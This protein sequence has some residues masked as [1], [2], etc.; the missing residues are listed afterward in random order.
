MDGKGKVLNSSKSW[1]SIPKINT[2][3][4]IILFLFFPFMATRVAKGQIGA[5]AAAANLYHS[6][7]NTRSELHLWP[8]P[9]F[10]AMPDL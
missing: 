7:S 4:K 9:Q 10:A 1:I 6:H 2:I 3:N 8:T 5:E